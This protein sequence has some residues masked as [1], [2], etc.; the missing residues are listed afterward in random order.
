MAVVDRL[1]LVD[2]DGVEIVDLVVGNSHIVLEVDGWV[3]L[4]CVVDF[5]EATI[6]VGV[7]FEVDE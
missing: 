7:T 2:E 5:A 4:E 6:L 1:A 3:V